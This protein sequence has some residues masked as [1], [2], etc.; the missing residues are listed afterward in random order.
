MQQAN[1]EDSGNIG[2]RQVAADEQQHQ[3]MPSALCG[4]FSEVRAEFRVIRDSVAK[5]K[6]P[7]DLVVGDSR[8]GVSKGDLPKFNIIQKSARYRETV[9]KLLSACDPS[10]VAVSQPSVWHTLQE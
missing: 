3:A 6:L 9:L 10:D 1:D 4:L 7:P 2:R 5:V 8:P